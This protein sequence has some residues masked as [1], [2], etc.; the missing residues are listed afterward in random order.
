M[1]DVDALG[2]QLAR[3][4]LGEAAQREFPHREG[5]RERIALDARRRPGEPDRAGAAREHSPRRLLA[6]EKPA[7]GGNRQHL[8]HRRRIQIGD[9]AAQAPARVIDHAIRYEAQPVGLG[10]KRRHLVRHRRI[11]SQRNPADF[12]GQGR[13]FF[14]IPRRQRNPGTLL[15]EPARQR[16]AQSGAGADDQRGPKMRFALAVRGFHRLRRNRA[17]GSAETTRSRHH[18]R[19]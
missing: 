3:H 5:G 8:G 1:H 17:L 12:G 19:D 2:M 11:A 16:R 14:G 6:D 7:I 9:R 18:G 4:A 13:E 15:G 10:E